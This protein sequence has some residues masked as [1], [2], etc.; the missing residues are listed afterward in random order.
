MPSNTAITRSQQAQIESV[1]RERF[2]FTALRPLQRRI[3]ERLM[4]GA[5]ALA[6]MPTGAGKSLCYQLPALAIDRPGT[7]LVFS[8][9]IALMEDQVAA[10][11]AKGI[12]AVYVNS[13]LDRKER[14][15]RYAR[16]AEGAFDLVYAT[17][18]R[19]HKPEFTE[20]LSSVPG[21]VKLLAVDEAHCISR[22]GHDLRP[23]Y[24]RVGEFRGQLGSPVTIALT[25]TATP[26]CRDDIKRALG[27][28]DDS[29]PTI[30]API[31][32]PN[33]TIETRQTW[34]D[35]AKID[36]IRDIAASR[37]GTGI[38]YFALIKDL[39]RFA[40][41]LRHRLDRPIAIYHGRLDPAQKKRV[42]Q[43]FIDAAPGDN[44]LLLATNAFGMGVDKPDIRFIIHA[45]IPGSLESYYQEIGRAGRDGLPATCAMLY[46][47]DDLAIQHRFVEW[48][49]PGA[50]LLVRIA[51]AA[52]RSAHEDFSEDEL[53][54]AALG[55]GGDGG[56]LQHCFITLEKLGVFEPT[57]FPDRWRLTR[58]LDH[59]E[60][61]PAEIEAKTKRD[62]QRL[63]N[64]VELTRS[65]DP[66]RVILDYFGPGGE[67]ADPR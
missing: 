4:S 15:R 12:R 37:P 28:D 67:N 16:I 33:L 54:L 8:P 63:L 30:S 35:D 48:A 31:D 22:W 42:Y 34:D 53:R 3:I 57:G 39:D 19:M 20:A 25:A 11:R 55:K 36:A 58:P 64:V 7:T 50:D 14:L 17:P 52:E 9:L 49:N 32:R 1:L 6:I 29:M 46:S 45:Q 44:L 18:E 66:R 10:L 26:E 2:G 51:D 27:L 23:A 21:G 62:L 60:I 59:A 43:R 56:R 61:D 24:Q 41:L 65:D 5:G 13:T 40:D 38:V 47:A